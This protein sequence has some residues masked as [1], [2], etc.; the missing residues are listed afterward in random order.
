ML[1]KTILILKLQLE[2]EV[3]LKNTFKR[4][5]TNQTGLLFRKEMDKFQGQRV[6]IISVITSYH[7][8]GEISFSFVAMRINGS[9]ESERFPLIC[10]DRSQPLIRNG[11]HISMKNKRIYLDSPIYG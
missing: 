5:F 3:Y 11:K 7:D 4:Y 1:G 8:D 10:V 6:R 9:K 2:D